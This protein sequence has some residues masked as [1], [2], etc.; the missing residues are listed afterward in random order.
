MT[1]PNAAVE[2]TTKAAVRALIKGG[3]SAISEN[4]TPAII[5]TF[6]ST[7]QGQTWPE[8]VAGYGFP[9]WVEDAILHPTN[10]SLS[11]TGTR[12]QGKQILTTECQSDVYPANWPPFGTQQQVGQV[13]TKT[14]NQS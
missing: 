8:Y 4:I 6:N 12:V 13:H 5:A 14:T 7:V 9:N 11:N 10:P 3:A 1:T 2:A